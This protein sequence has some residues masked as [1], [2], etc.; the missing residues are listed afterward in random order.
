M[1]MLDWQRKQVR[2]NNG[3]DR[4]RWLKTAVLIGGSVALLKYLKRG[5]GSSAIERE[6]RMPGDG[7][8]PQA[9]SRTTHAIT[10]P[11]PPSSIWPWL[12]QMGYG[13][14]GWYIDAW[15]NQWLNENFWQRFVPPEVQTEHWPSSEEIL[16][17][18]QDLAVGDT[19][20]DGPPG[21]AFFTVAAIELQRHLVLFSSTHVQYLTPPFLMDT[22]LAIKGQFCWSF[23]LEE[24]QGE[25]TRLL[26]RMSGTMQPTMLRILSIPLLVTADYLFTR[27]MLLG[28]KRRAAPQFA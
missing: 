25:S 2:D 8:I 20:P 15:W 9:H 1:L 6:L 18:W 23:V 28:I 13:R 5:Y 4:R 24:L 12:L 26:L 11:V 16:P 21:T 17:E 10:I 7:L 3:A 14:G 27:Q 22:L 19:V